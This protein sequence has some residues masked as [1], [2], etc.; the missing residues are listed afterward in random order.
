MAA[1]FVSSIVQL[2]GDDADAPSDGV[3]LS[4]LLRGRRAYDGSFTATAIAPFREQAVSLPEFGT[5]DCQSLGDLL[6][7][8]ALKYLDK[9]FERMKADVVET[10]SVR[11]YFDPLLNGRR[12]RQFVRKLRKKCLI[13]FTGAP[14]CSVGMF[15]VQKKDERIKLIIDS[16]PANGLFKKP[17]G[18]HLCTSEGLSRIELQIPDH[19]VPGNPDFDLYLNEHPIFMQFLDVDN[20]SH[21]VRLPHDLSRYFCLP[22]G[23]A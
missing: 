11:P 16:R 15:F 22:P 9:D 5:D 18:V 2:P 12:Y 8:S 1:R 7:E 21:R 23:K 14:L 6:P 20:A 4:A 10:E 13:N 3:A 17:P 19:L